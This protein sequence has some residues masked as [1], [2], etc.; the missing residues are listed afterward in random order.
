MWKWFDV[1]MLLYA[2]AFALLV[3]VWAVAR[4]PSKARVAWTKCGDLLRGWPLLLIF[5]TTFAVVL[6]LNPAKAG[7][8]FWGVSKI[9]LC[10]YLGYWADRLCFRPEDRPHALVGISRGAAW[11]RRAL[12][13]AAAILAGGMIP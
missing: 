3:L 13:V 2:A 4:W 11:K 12:I 9:A 5:L 1:S 7:L 10:G 6:W 8:A